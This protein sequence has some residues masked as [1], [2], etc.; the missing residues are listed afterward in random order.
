M[1]LAAA[2]ALCALYFRPL[3]FETSGELQIIVTDAGVENG[4]PKLNTQTYSELS[5]EQMVKICELLDGFDYRRTPATPFTNG[6]LDDLDG[7]VM[8]LYFFEDDGAGRT[9]AI[10]PA[11]KLAIDG[12][13]YRFGKAQQCVEKL[14]KI[15]ETNAN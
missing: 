3:K 7:S 9:Y 12:K 10:T 13:T 5:E 8:H 4:E 11:G 2:C 6:T 15:L 14:R 1:I